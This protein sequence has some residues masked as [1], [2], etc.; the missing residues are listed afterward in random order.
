[1]LA[2]ALQAGRHAQQFGFIHASGNRQRSQLGLAHG[3][4]AG[5]IKGHYVHFVRQFQRLRVL[6]QNAML[7][8]HASTGHDGRRRSQAQCTRAGNHQHRHRV[9]HCQF[10]S[11]AGQPPAQQRDNRKHQHHG[12]KHRAHLIDQPL[13]RCL[14]CLRVFHQ[15]D[16]AREHGLATHRAHLHHHT[17][18]AIDG[19]TRERSASVLGHRQRLTGQ[20]GF[21]HLGVPFQQHAIHR[22]PLTG[23]D[24][25]PVTHQHFGH[26]HIHL[27][28]K[29]HQV[30]HIRPQ[31][32]QGADGRRGLALGT[33]FQPL[34]QHHQ[35]DHNG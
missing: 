2:A 19:A 25:Q 17:A 15:A 13:D 3:Q 33:R 10:E 35:R 26:R 4:R 6:D 29:P 7:R 21:V 34:A 12:H 32:V 8:S 1:M 30:R 16:D 5:F 22:K 14:G 24:D 31:G 27:T 9:D 28:I 18:I 23:F 11:V 20:H